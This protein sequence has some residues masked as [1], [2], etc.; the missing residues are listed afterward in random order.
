[1]LPLYIICRL[2]VTKIAAR[3]LLLEI[4]VIGCLGVDAAPVGRGPRCCDMQ[5]TTLDGVQ[6][7]I[8]LLE[9][10]RSLHVGVELGLRR[11]TSSKGLCRRAHMSR[12]QLKARRYSCMGSQ[13]ME[14]MMMIWVQIQKR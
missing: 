14:A 11:H 3:L 5:G 9:I 12:L 1:M 8:S 13:E 6:E 2:T 10:V 7:V 4:Q